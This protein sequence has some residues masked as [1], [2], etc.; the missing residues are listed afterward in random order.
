MKKLIIGIAFVLGVLVF[1][2][3]VLVVTKY[4]PPSKPVAVNSFE[5]CL[6]AGYPIMESYPRQCKTPDGRTFAEELVVDV[7]YQNASADMITVELPYPGAVT[8]K[9]FSAIGKARGYWFFEASFPVRVVDPNGVT[10]TVAVA[11]AQSEWM[12]T[13]FVPFKADI[14]IPDT[15]IGPATIIFEKDN[16][17]GLPENNASISFPITIE[18]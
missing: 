3:A 12:T 10:L 2:A 7:S 5:E 4:S 17:S 1:G 14:V 8:G 16:P 13:D 11:Q 18:Y 9:Q 15:Y 6:A